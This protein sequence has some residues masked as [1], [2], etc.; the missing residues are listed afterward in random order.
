MKEWQSAMRNYYNSASAT[1][2]NCPLED[3]ALDSLRGGVRG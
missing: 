2:E 1:R 3:V